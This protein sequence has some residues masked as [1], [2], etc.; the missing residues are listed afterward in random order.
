MNDYSQ[1]TVL[2]ERIIHKYNQWEMCIRDSS[3]SM[4]PQLSGGFPFS[5]GYP[6]SWMDHDGIR[7][8]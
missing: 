3:V 1:M 2:M 6:V 7:G 8:V 4:E 5:R